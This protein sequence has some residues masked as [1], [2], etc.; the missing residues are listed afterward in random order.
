MQRLS[1]IGGE[2]FRKTLVC[3][4]EIGLKT[5]PAISKI[6]KLEG[7]PYIEVLKLEKLSNSELKTILKNTSLK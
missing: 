5:E 3:L 4:K 7:D 1:A 6:L 2:D